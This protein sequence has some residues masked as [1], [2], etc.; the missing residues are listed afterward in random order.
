MKSNR[1]SCVPQILVSSAV[2]Y[3]DKSVDCLAN[4]ALKRLPLEETY[5]QI[6][7]VQFDAVDILAGFRLHLLASHLRLLNG[8]QRASTR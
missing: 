5:P 6:G 2:F 8:D 7:R 3:C 1:I 4:R